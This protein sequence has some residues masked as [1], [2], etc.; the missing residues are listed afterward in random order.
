MPLLSSVSAVS[1]GTSGDRMEDDAL[2]DALARIGE[3]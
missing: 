3:M 1:T 2:S